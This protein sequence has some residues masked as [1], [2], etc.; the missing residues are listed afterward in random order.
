LVLTHLVVSSL[1]AQSR[2]TA[3]TLSALLH[4]LFVV[5]VRAR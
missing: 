4:H 2:Y 5:V 1:A 3:S